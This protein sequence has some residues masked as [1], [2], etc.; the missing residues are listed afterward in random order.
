MRYIGNKIGSQCFYT[1]KLLCHLIDVFGN[2]IK[3][4]IGCKLDGHANTHA[5]IAFNHLGRRFRDAFDRQF[6]R[7]MTAEQ[8]N[9]NQNR[10]NQN[11]ICH[12]NLCRRRNFF[13]GKRNAERLLQNL[14]K[15]GQATAD[16]KRNQ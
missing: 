13:L 7:K 3:A 12:G 5:E 15:Q 10:T 6:Y 14:Y 1:G 8:I 16:H 2:F 4:V 9:G 11:H